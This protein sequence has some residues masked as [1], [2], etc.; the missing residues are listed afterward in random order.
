MGL[1]ELPTRELGAWL[2]GVPARP[3]ARRRNA[4]LAR[5]ARAES[6]GAARGLAR[7]QAA[8]RPTRRERLGRARGDGGERGRSDRDCPRGAEL[9]LASRARGRF[10]RAF[11]VG[12]RGA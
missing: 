8:L 2:R 10:S 4:V 6:F 11:H 7:A 3:A 1:W 9:L 5:V 12:R